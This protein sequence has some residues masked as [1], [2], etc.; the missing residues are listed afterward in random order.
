MWHCA[1]PLDHPV[2]RYVG[3]PRLVLGIATAD[4]GVIASEPDLLEPLQT[5]L[6]SR[7]FLGAVPFDSLKALP[8]FVGGDCV[9]GVTDISITRNRK[10]A[11]I[12]RLNGLFALTCPSHI[13]AR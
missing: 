12:A 6:V 3:Q 10:T 13:P 7:R 1:C 4:I 8:V 2:Q 9:T 11:S 5:A